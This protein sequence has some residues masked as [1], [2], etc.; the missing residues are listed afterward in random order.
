[1]QLDSIVVNLNYV[2]STN[3]G[4]YS[5]EAFFDNP[6][7]YLSTTPNP[8]ASQKLQCDTFSGRHILL[9]SYFTNW[10]TEN[11]SS[12]SCNP[13][14]LYN[15]FYFS[16]GSCCDNYAGGNLFPYEYRNFNYL[17]KIKVALPKGYSF[18]SAAIYYYSSKGTSN[19][20]SYYS[21]NLKPTIKNQD[22]LIFN[23]DTL[24]NSTKGIFKRSDEGYQGTLVL[25]LI[26]GCKAAIN[27]YETVKYSSYFK[28]PD[29]GVTDIIENYSDSLKFDHPSVLLAAINSISVSKK[30]TFSW[31]I[32]MSNTKSGSSIGN[33]W[34]SNS[35]P[36]KAKILAIKD[37]TTGKDLPLKNGIFKAGNLTSAS[38]RSFRIYAT[39]SN[40]KADSFKIAVGWNCENYPDSLEVYSCK[41]LLSYINLILSP[42]PPLIISTLLED[43]TRT[44]VCTIRKYQAIITNVDEDNIYNL[45][46]KVTIPPGT[47]FVDTGMYY[48]FPYGSKFAKLSKPVLV[49]GNTYE[50]A[51]SDS[52]S[53]LKNGLE[54]VSDTT[55]NRIRVQFLLE[56][57]CQITA[58]AFVS[59]MPD[60]KIGCGEPVRRIGY[61]GK[62]IKIKGVDNPYFTLISL[63]PD[64]INLCSPSVAFK[65]KII[66]LGPTNTL[67]NDSLMLSLPIGFDPDTASLSTVR[68]KGRG[69]VKNIN[70]E[71]R[72]AWAIPQG[73]LPG[74]SS[75]LE[76]KLT[77]NQ[78]APPC[79]AESFAMQSVT[80]KKAYCVKSK[81]SCDINV[82]TGSF[83]KALKLDRAEPV[84]KLSSRHLREK[85]RSK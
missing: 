48:S 74:D 15:S 64:S 50:W 83:Y 59:I 18:S 5:G 49:T 23:L 32:I 38:T 76:F 14:T 24:F 13:V 81:D 9:G 11:Y 21:A 77:I 12:N 80:K 71:K 54:R 43:T 4:S 27:T 73:L 79:G 65:S 25:N 6:E 85:M 63:T 16:A 8:T 37:L 52:L 19:Y 45:K 70:G 42:E 34:M 82:A 68:I 10:Y 31:D 33:V 53:V 46:L 47:L 35:L 55:K 60:G 51:L 56:T 41:N 84:I 7:F 72:W 2:Y 26:P 67:V 22:T 3:I 75:M 36:Q 62:P 29:L 40:C 58:G 28:W 30:D 39:S 17:D 44:D 20:T 66:Y 78:N 57:N 1:M 61:T 69:I